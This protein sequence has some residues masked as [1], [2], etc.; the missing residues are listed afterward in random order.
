MIRILNNVFSS[1]YSATKRPRTPMVFSIKSGVRDVEIMKTTQSGFE[2][3]H[4]NRYTSL[5]ETRD[6]LLGTSME[7]EWNFSESKLMGSANIEKIDFNGLRAKIT[8]A[9]INTFAGPSDTGVYS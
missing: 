9:L 5:P 8:S 2:G 4:R 6:R 3:F 7:A 1:P